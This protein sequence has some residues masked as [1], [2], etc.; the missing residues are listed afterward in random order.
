MNFYIP[1]RLGGKA[2]TLDALINVEDI[3]P[4]ILGLSSIEIPNSVEGI[5]YSRYI[6]GGEDPGDN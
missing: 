2:S 5:D 6:R 1:E 4:T 3:I